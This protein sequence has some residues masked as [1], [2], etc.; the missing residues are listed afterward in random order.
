MNL[1]KKRLWR[2]FTVSSER[3]LTLKTLEDPEKVA[4]NIGDSKPTNIEIGRVTTTNKQPSVVMTLSPSLSRFLKSTTPPKKRGVSPSQCC[5]KIV[6][7]K[8]KRPAQAPDASIYLDT[9]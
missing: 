7:R 6:T 1:D 8:F 3:G 4:L 5:A 9:M 2:R